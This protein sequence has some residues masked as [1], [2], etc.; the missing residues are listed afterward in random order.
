MALL[1][2]WSVPVSWSL[3]QVLHCRLVPQTFT[4]VMVC[5][6]WSVLW[7]GQGLVFRS[8][9]VPTISPA[10]HDWSRRNRCWTPKKYRDPS[11]LRKM[12]Q[13]LEVIEE[14][15]PSAMR[16]N[17]IGNSRFQSGCNVGALSDYENVSLMRATHECDPDSPDRDASTTINFKRDI[18]PKQ[19]P[20]A[21]E[22][23]LQ[24]PIVPL[25]E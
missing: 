13:K 16:G 9:T 3:Q 6:T 15:A 7:H 8:S 23:P 21:T 10:W 22:A 12:C 1:C 14:V 17:L 4:V 25:P 19:K 20:D 24:P 2:V 5:P 18:R 11:C